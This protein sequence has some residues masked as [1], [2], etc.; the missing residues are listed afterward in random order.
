MAAMLSVETRSAEDLL[1]AVRRGEDGELTV[2]VERHWPQLERWVRFRLHP[3]LRGRVDP[4]D[5]VQDAFLSVCRRCPPCVAVQRLPFLQWLRLK[6]GQ[7]LAETHRFHLGARMRD[8]RQEVSLERGAGPPAT[9]ESLAEQHAGKGPSASEAA[10]R[11]ELRRRV[12]DALQRMAPEHREA[13]V[14]RH[15][16]ELS[17]AEAARVLGITLA[18]AC[19]RY[20]RALQRLRTLFENMPGGLEAVWG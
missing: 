9:G 10:I 1:E 2:L 17:N 19:K 8:A 3:R 15:F 14:L 4:A 20:F 13:L 5:V 11:T 7:K 12:Q 18:A 6:V 16:E